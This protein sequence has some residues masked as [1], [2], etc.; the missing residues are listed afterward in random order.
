MVL[1]EE[2]ISQINKAQYK[3][4]TIEGIEYRTFYNKVN[5]NLLIIYNEQIIQNH[6]LREEINNIAKSIREVIKEYTKYNLW[7]TYF[8]IVVNKN[9]YN[10]KYYYIERDVRNL[11]KYVIQTEMDIFRLPFLD[12]LNSNKEAKQVE[13]SLYFT[14]E[15]IK[16]L[17]LGIRNKGGEQKKLTNAEINKILEEMNFLEGNSDD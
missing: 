9:S 4:I 12:I 7:N 15:K 3:E 2:F 6:L 17:Y 5:G 8:L 13:E 10:E 11:R 1:F 14:S 16:E